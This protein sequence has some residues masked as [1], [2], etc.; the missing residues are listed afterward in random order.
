MLKPTAVP[1]LPRIHP[2]QVLNLTSPST[3]CREEE[4]H[5]KQSDE[6]G[7]KLSKTNSPSWRHW[8][9]ILEVTTGLCCLFPRHIWKLTMD[10]TL[11][12]ASGWSTTSFHNPGSCTVKRLCLHR[13]QTSISMLD[14][15]GSE[16]LLSHSECQFYARL[17]YS[18][19]KLPLRFCTTQTIV[20]PE[21][22]WSP[23]G[24]INYIK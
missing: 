18:V 8:K 17:E 3:E 6:G 14:L 1:C 12:V 9:N 2:L 23:R 7:V 20:F 15:P 11:W 24:K 22:H 19:K 16:H 13:P 5:C 21:Y 4:L 10:V